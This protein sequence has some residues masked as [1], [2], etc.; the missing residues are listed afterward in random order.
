MT[1]TIS[2]NPRETGLE[3]RAPFH[4]VSRELP[5]SGRPSGWN[6]CPTTRIGRLAFTPDLT[7][8]EIGMEAWLAGV[9]RDDLRLGVTSQLARR[10]LRRTPTRSSATKCIAASRC[11]IPGIDDSRNELLWSPHSP[12]IIDVHVQLWGERGELHR[13][14]GFVHRAPVRR[15]AGRSISAQRSPLSAANGP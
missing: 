1:R 15:G 6:R 10:F 12:T 2:Q 7:R 14:G 9:P 3:S 5:G 4:L 13:R 11:L 8:W